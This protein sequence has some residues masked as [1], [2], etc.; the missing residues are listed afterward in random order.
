[1]INS[2]DVTCNAILGRNDVT[3][4]ARYSFQREDKKIQHHRARWGHIPYRYCLL[5]VVWLETET[6]TGLSV[7]FDSLLSWA[8]GSSW[9]IKIGTI[10]RSVLGGESAFKLKSLLMIA[11]A[12]VPS[13]L[14]PRRLFRL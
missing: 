12:D 2:M 4:N 6:R 7:T 13:P 8:T 3:C 11:I 1:M 10:E 5:P 14:E 9:A